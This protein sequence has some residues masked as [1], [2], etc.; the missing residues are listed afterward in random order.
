MLNISLKDLPDGARLLVANA[1]P[2]GRD[3]PRFVTLRRENNH[4]DQLIDDAGRSFSGLYGDRFKPDTAVCK[5]IDIVWS[6]PSLALSEGEIIEYFKAVSRSLFSQRKEEGIQP[7]MIHVDMVS[8]STATARIVQAPD[9]HPKAALYYDYDNELGYVL[10][11]VK[12]SKERFLID[13]KSLPENTHPGDLIFASNFDCH[14]EKVSDDAEPLVITSLKGAETLGLSLREEDV[15]RYVPGDGSM[16]VPVIS[17]E[18]FDWHINRE[19]AKFE[20]NIGIF[21]SVPEKDS[22]EAKIVHLFHT[23]VGLYGLDSI[24]DNFALETLDIGAWAYVD[25]KMVGGWYDTYYGPEYDCELI[26]D[27]IPLT[28]E[29]LALLDFNL[30]ELGSNII[31]YVRDAGH[32]IEGTPEE[33]GRRYMEMAR[34]SVENERGINADNFEPGMA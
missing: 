13:K 8:D 15:L 31:D 1:E 22:G 29:H 5:N 7:L 34:I 32:T 16:K 24:D 10:S 20:P 26:G 14:G 12:F 18:D 30:E 11:D 2:G 3:N 21:I 17:I 28:D 27:F 4:P 33:V 9:S 23:G 6:T 25:P 19:L